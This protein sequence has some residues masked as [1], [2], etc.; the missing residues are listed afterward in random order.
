MKGLMEGPTYRAFKAAGVGDAVAEEA[1]EA[2]VARDHDI[3][4][5]HSDMRLLKWMVGA[6]L[7]LL[8][9]VFLRLFDVV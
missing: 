6:N 7:A 2:V 5:L 8:L 1:V 4:E 9:P 3:A